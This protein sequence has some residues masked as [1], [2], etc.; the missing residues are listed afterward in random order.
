MAGPHDGRMNGGEMRGCTA[1]G[2]KNRFLKSPVVIDG[3]RLA[4][5]DKLGGT[6]ATW[7]HAVADT[8][9]LSKCRYGGI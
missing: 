5:E 6:S 1:E 8:D 9:S 4:T 3:H 7:R 2:L